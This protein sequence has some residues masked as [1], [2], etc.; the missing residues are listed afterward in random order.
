MRIVQEAA[1]TGITGT[2]DNKRS[3]DKIPSRGQSHSMAMG[4]EIWQKSER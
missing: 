1:T 3:F 4:W 2:I